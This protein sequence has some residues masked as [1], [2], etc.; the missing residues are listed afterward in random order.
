[1]EYE[2]ILAGA[3][4]GFVASFLKDVLMGGWRRNPIKKKRLHRI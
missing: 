2:V 1:M 3:V 4:A